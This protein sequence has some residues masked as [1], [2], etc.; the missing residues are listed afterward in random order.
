[1]EKGEG[2]RGTKCIVKLSKLLR[3]N[4]NFCQHSIARQVGLHAPPAAMRT[5]IINYKNSMPHH[6][7]WTAFQ[8]YF[9]TLLAKYESE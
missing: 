1:L 9:D 5:V 3:A 2:K 4:N 6:F 7:K 8:R